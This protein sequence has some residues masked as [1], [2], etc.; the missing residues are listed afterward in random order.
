MKCGVPHLI[1][2]R[3]DEFIENFNEIDNFDHIR[4]IMHDKTW[5]EDEF[6][7]LKMA[8]RILGVL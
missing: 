6:E 7:L 1:S 3:V 8:E 4:N 2:S 5:K